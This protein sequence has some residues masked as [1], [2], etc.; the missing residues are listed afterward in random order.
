MSQSVEQS[1]IKA[2]E[3][4]VHSAYQRQGS[5]LRATV[6]SR[7][8]VKGSSTTFQVIGKGI[9]ATKS[10]NGSVPIMNIDHTP[11]EITL[12]DFYAGDWIDKLDEIK[13]S[14]DEKAVIAS[15]GAYALGRKTDD[16]L[17]DALKGNSSITSVIKSVNGYRNTDGLTKKKILAAFETMGE[18]D[19]PDDGERTAIVGWKQWSDLMEIDEFA[20]ANYVGSDDLP[21]RGTQAKRWLGTLWLPHSGLPKSS[22]VRTCYWYHKNALAHASGSDVQSDITWHG[23]RA[24]HFVNN[25][26]SQGAGVIDASGIVKLECAE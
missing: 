20:N 24:A 26:M 23:D 4:E 5:K 10:R 13:I 11:V 1:F 18:N 19:V 6:R 2:F 25:M 7:N 15:A 14:H 12:N 22:T 21:W 8:N 16:L 17:I 3:A 9:A